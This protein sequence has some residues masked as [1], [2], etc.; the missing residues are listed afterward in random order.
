[1]YVC[2]NDHCLNPTLKQVDIG[3]RS[4]LLGKTQQILDTLVEKIYDDTPLNNEEK[5][6]LNAT[7]LPVYKML[8]VVTAFRKG[9]APLDIQQYGELIALD[10][11]YRYVLEVLDIVHDSVVQLR[12]VQ[13]DEAH[14]QRFI[15]DLRH[16]RERIIQR[17][18]SAY[19]HMDSTLSMIQA[20][21][22][23]EKQLHSM[24]GS[25]ANE[26]NGM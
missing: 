18:G 17:R 8:N 21:Q 1:M 6:F 7:R 14:M 11:L 26:H 23:I 3:D 22:L 12:A 9:H 25:V 24:M 20:T 10:I 5:D 2:D 15:D 19:Q 16:A 4:A 13:V